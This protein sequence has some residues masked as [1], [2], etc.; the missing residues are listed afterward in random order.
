MLM[1]LLKW[2][3]L[4]A[5]LLWIGPT[6]GA[7]WLLR[8]ANYRFGDPGL[9]SQYLYRAFLHL[10]WLE[11]AAL[12]LLLGSGLALAWA[13]HSFSADWLQY[14]LMLVLLI[15]VPLEV[16]DIWFGHIRL[17]RLFHERHP[18]KPYTRQEAALVNFYHTRFTPLALLLMPVAIGVIM[19]LAITKLGPSL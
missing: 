1:A 3:H 6:L 11:H 13:Q 9:V 5:L 12:A 14:K 2:L 19:W 18:A 17:P 10:L 7:W 8:C 15:I 4:G 16:I